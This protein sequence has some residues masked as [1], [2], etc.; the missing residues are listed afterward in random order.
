M[1]A[2]VASREDADGFIWEV[3]QAWSGGTQ[4]GRDSLVMRTCSQPFENMSLKAMQGS[5][6]GKYTCNR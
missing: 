5:I 3:L 1:L 6:D 2:H 4:S